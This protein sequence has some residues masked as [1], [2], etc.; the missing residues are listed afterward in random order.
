MIPNTLYYIMCYIHIG[1]LMLSNVIIKEHRILISPIDK[2]LN[3]RKKS[4][5][6]NFIYDSIQAEIFLNI[7]KLL[8]T[9]QF[10]QLSVSII[11][12]IVHTCK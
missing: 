11:S 3:C 5:C 4:Y 6:H 1:I 7:Y 12:T 2:L 8:G 10:S 9:L